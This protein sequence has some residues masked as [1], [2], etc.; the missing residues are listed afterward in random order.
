MVI[1]CYRWLWCGYRWLY[2][3]IGDYGWLYVVIG[4]YRWLYGVTLQCQTGL[5]HT[6]LCQTA[7]PMVS[8]D[9]VRAASFSFHSPIVGLEK[10]ALEVGRMGCE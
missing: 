3:V 4:R 10:T 6:T 5:D 9:S 2:G 1:G 8:Y 7:T